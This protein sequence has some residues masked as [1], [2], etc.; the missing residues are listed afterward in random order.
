MRY[1][2]RRLPHFDVVG[3]PLFVTFRLYDSLP[4]N[5]VFLPE[6][7]TTG[8][9][10]VEMDR[11]LDR[12]DS[13]PKY[14]AI[15]EIAALVVEAIR[16]GE[17][18]FGRYQLDSFVVMPNHVHLLLTPSVPSAKW[19]PTLKGFTAHEANLILSRTGN[20]FWQSESYD[21]L[22]RP[23]EYDRI[24]RYIENNPVKAGLVASPEDFLWSSAR[25]C[26]KQAAG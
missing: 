16:D 13:G 3:E 19:L 11:L 4:N 22:V 15:P 2:Q 23:D 26:L 10:F 25:A 24:R 8:K 20:P 6:S 7:L 21:H 12:A 5:R 9:A 18:R 1:Y 17:R 14:L